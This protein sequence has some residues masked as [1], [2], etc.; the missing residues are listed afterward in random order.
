MNPGV[1]TGTMNLERF[2]KS[3][4][5]VDPTT[6]QVSLYSSGKHGYSDGARNVER[7]TASLVL[8]LHMTFSEETRAF[9]DTMFIVPKR[10]ES[11]A[12]ETTNGIVQGI[13]QSRA[14]LPA[15][16]KNS[17]GRLITEAFRHLHIGSRVLR[18]AESPERWAAF[19]FRVEDVIP[20][21]LRDD[22]LLPPP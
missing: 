22:L 7:F 9:H 11:F 3:L 21:W 15:A 18:I 1:Y 17:G 19:G 20:A 8:G 16:V 13:K 14:G 2:H 10:L 5:G 6:L 4:L 12:V